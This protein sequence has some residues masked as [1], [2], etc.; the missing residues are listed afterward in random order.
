MRINPE[1]WAHSIEVPC[2]FTVTK[3]D[4]IARPSEVKKIYEN[5]QS[6]EK[7]FHLFPGNHA[8]S[9]QLDVTYQ[10]INFM[11]KFNS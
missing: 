5:I 8:S 1:E 9:R 2:F 11:L 4:T 3:N 7:E 6:K 10:A